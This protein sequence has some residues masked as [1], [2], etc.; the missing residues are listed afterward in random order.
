MRGSK[1]AFLR[2]RIAGALAATLALAGTLALGLATAP[3]AQAAST[4]SYATAGTGTFAR[5]ICWFDL[6]GYDASQATSAG[7]QA[8]SVTVPGGYVVSY[9]LNLSG[10]SINPATLPTYSGAYFGNHSHYTGISGKPAYY[11]TGSGTTTATLSNISVVD[12][13][14][15]PVNGFAFVGADMEST[16]AGESIT[17]NSDQN[18]QS[19]TANSSGNG[20]G[21]ACNGGFT[22]VGTTQ[23]K[24]SATSSSTKTGA[25]ILAAEDPT[26]FSQ[27]MVGSGREAV[28][29]GVLVS[30]VRLTKTVVNRYSG[31]AFHIAVADHTNAVVAQA[32]TSG[33]STATTGE[34]TVLTGLS[35]ATY[36]LS[37]SATAG[38]LA[39]YTGSW[40]CTRNGATDSAL[41][42][43]DAGPSNTVNVDVGDFVDCTITNTAK[44][45]ELTLVKHAGTP[46]DVNGNGITDAGDTIPYTFDLSN[47]GQLGVDGITINDAK[48]G[49]ITCAATSLAPGDSTTC[50]ADSPY[51]ITAADQTAGTVH[52]SAT[53]TGTPSGTT[54]TVTSAPST[55]DT[56]VE[57]PQPAISIIKMATPHDINGDFQI[58]LGD[59]IE[60][61]FA[62]HNTGNVALHGIAVDDPSAGSVT[63]PST[64]LIAGDTMTCTADAQHTIDQSDVD[65]GVVDNTATV[66]GLAPDGSTA[67][68]D[69]SSTD[70]PIAQTAS[71]VA[72]KHAAVTDQNADGTTDLGDT[73]RWSVTL[74][75]TGTSTLHS[76]SIDDPTAGAFTCAATT[77]APDASTTC[78]ADVAYTITQADADNGEVDNTATGH[79]RDPGGDTVDSGSTQATVTI[80]NTPSLA[81]TK[82][83]VIADTSGDGHRGVGDTITFTFTAQNTGTN[84]LHGLAIDDPTFGPATCPVT[85]LAPG[86]S[87][88]CTA[89][90]TYTVT[91]ADVDAGLVTN[92]ATASAAD[93]QGNPVTSNTSTTDTPLD[94]VVG[95]Q[96]VKHG[97]AHDQDGDGKIG[98]GDT[99]DWTFTATNSGLV[100]LTGVTV[101]DPK[102]GSVTCA[103]TTLA[104]GAST[105]C[106]ADSPYT[107][108][109]A[110]ATSGAVH[111]TASVSGDCG[112]GTTVSPAVAAAVVA[113]LTSPPATTTSTP[114][115]SVSPTKIG[116][117]G[118]L[119]FTGGVL[120]LPTLAAGLLAV[121]A[122]AALL[123]TTRRRG[124]H[125]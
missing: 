39:D 94:Q 103:A 118:S 18:I 20:I 80:A 54:D 7:G 74:H 12:S 92:S 27:V 64:T 78:T 122:G 112:C 101:S 120:L 44:P 65:A 110:D 51:T 124:R 86:D 21:N 115:P 82:H 104:P 28:G 97:T 63:C 46:T 10:T 52:N 47:T 87:T 69:P 31:D 13:S 102:A 36:T 29:F 19:L 90:S 81:I 9:T 67:D 70:T 116:A 93:P 91:Q 76:L 117:A 24:C 59:T 43:G 11:Q 85:T 45:S 25:A 106:A 35:T 15:N 73:I 83:A 14:N 123:L 98:V 114:S 3:S 4:C 119:P 99:I 6:T 96:L 100:T 22:G 23:V 62:V 121:L 5:T 68:G 57:S 53:A 61:T 125:S 49:S 108:T 37:E 16:D 113:N 111:N 58:D 66:S 17:W 72:T 56:T 2:R 32:D 50:A 1:R 48:V 77:L 30:K 26:T 33:T 88:T 75:N 55:T 41:P 42:S 60:F 79:A 71:L 40:A 38:T 84:T 8:F 105:S 89:D 107:I 34:V 95:L 109:T